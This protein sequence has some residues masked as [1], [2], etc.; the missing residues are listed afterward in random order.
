MDREQC[1]CGGVKIRGKSHSLAPCLP[2][3]FIAKKEL[4]SFP[5]ED[6]VLPLPEHPGFGSHLTRSGFGF[7]SLRQRIRC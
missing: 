3:Q 7:L 1:V 6:S 5:E 2:P 4:L